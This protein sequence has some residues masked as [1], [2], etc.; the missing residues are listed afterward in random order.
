MCGRYRLTAKQ[1]YLRDHF[2]LDEDL[3]WAPRWNIAPTQQ[4]PTV[5]QHPKEPRRIFSL[6]RWGLIPHW[7]KDASIGLRTI[8]AMSETAAE[9]P[10]F[11]DAFRFRRCLIPADGFYEWKKIG[12]KQKQPY[13][14]GTLDG[15]VFAFAGLW[16]RYR[17]RD[18]SVQET[19]AILTNPPN[20]LVAEVHDRMSARPIASQ[21]T[22]GPAPL[23]VVCPSPMT[24]RMQESDMEALGLLF[25]RYS[26]LTLGRPPCAARQR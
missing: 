14:F 22:A 15:S 10:V 21:S 17:Q 23:T 2:G 4:I 3:S 20:A 25:H 11:R 6:M 19:C 8:N 5:R 12:P 13:D 26:K 24:L 1:R 9:K 7:A 16:D 18:K